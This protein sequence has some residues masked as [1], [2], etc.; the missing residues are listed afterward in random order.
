MG[1]GSKIGGLRLRPSWCE[2]IREGLEDLAAERESEAA[3]LVLIGAPRLRRLGLDVPQ[4]VLSMPEHRLYNRLASSHPESAHSRYNALS[5][6]LCASS[7]PSNASLTRP[8]P[9]PP[10]YERPRERRKK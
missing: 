4:S 7:E 10:L 9:N 8:G 6:A 5:G 1:R 3:L 2:L